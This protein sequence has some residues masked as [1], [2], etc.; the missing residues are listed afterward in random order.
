MKAL[1]RNETHRTLLGLTKDFRKYN[2]KKQKQ[3]SGLVAKMIAHI[4]KIDNKSFNIVARFKYLN[5][6]Q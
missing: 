1:Y 3:C 5:I 6:H 4:I 2:K